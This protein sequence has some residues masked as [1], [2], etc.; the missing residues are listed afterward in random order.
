MIVDC[1]V[2][3]GV[4]MFE[5]TGRLPTRIMLPNDLH[6]MLKSEC[7]RKLAEPPHIV[8]GTISCIQLG[9]GFGI[10]EV[11]SANPEPTPSGCDG[12]KP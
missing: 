9:T 4:E 5:R 3:F 10:I 1:I 12:E 2:K 8:P 7:A 6:D 11:L